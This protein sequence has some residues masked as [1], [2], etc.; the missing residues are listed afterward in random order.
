[1][2]LFL[3]CTQFKYPLGTEGQTKIK[4]F[5]LKPQSHVTILNIFKGFS[6]WMF[7]LV[8][9]QLLVLKS[10]DALERG[11]CNSCYFP[12]SAE[13]LCVFAANNQTYRYF[14]QGA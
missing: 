10:A 13:G 9:Q 8:V 7:M 6:R 12:L 2:F 4:D 3:S 11:G 5:I 14:F 1:M